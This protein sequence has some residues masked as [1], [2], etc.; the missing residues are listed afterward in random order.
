[1]D[2]RDDPRTP[3]GAPMDFDDAPWTPLGA[4]LNLRDDP[5]MDEISSTVTGL[6]YKLVACADQRT[7]VLY[8]TPAKVAEIYRRSIYTVKRHLAK[9]HKAGLIEYTRA[10]KQDDL[11]HVRFMIETWGRQDGG[12][13]EM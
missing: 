12:S 6:L 2:G 1:M 10:N 8:A 7:T 3:L 5:R 9:L 11:L 13:H 4:L